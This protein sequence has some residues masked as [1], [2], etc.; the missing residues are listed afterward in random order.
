MR[1]AYVILAVAVIATWGLRRTTGE[2]EFHLSPLMSAV[3]A[4]IHIT[5]SSALP[6]LYMIFPP[7]VAE[8]EDLMEEDEHGIMRP[9]ADAV[10]SMGIENNFR[11]I[12]FEV[13]IILLCGF[14]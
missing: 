10:R 14:T 13:G 12:V 5:V 11:D 8:R 1:I 7:D 9:K 6:V 3:L 2:A 4:F